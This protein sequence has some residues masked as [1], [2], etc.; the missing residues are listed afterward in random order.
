MFMFLLCLDQVFVCGT[1]TVCGV[2]VGLS[3]YLLVPHV[4]V[5]TVP[6]VKLSCFFPQPLE[7][8]VP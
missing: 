5:M 4:V 6:Q 2:E 3:S 1:M 8:I 7:F